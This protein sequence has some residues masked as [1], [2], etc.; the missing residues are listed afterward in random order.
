MASMI[1]LRTAPRYRFVNPDGIGQGQRFWEIALKSLGV[2]FECGIKN[3]LSIF[4]DLLCPSI[5]DILRGEET[6]SGM[7]MFGV[8]PGEELLAERPG[9]FDASEP[10]GELRPVLHCLEMGFRV[11]I[12]IADMRPGKAFGD[13]QVSKQESDRFRGHTGAPIGMDAQFV[14]LDHLFLAGLFDQLFCQ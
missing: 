12:V 3:S 4:D 13:A 10:V 5:M 7:V 14:C 6:Y 1:T 8:V 9:V 11:G 2:F